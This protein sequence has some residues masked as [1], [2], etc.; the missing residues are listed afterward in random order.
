MRALLMLGLLVL[1]FTFF[2]CTNKIEGNVTVDGKALSWKSCRSGR[3]YGFA[4][5]EL[6]AQSGERLRLVMTPTGHNVAV[7]F[8]AS[9]TTGIT[10]G[11]CG[12]FELQNQS[13]S[14]NKVT[15]VQGKATLDCKGSVAL[16]GVVTFENC[17]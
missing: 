2:G 5:V 6:V 3:V 17:H 11:Q 9:T 12:P 15:N 1:A 13:S 8:K 14:V 16:K 4:G 7:Y 10:L